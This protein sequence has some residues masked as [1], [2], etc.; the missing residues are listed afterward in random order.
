MS[1]KILAIKIVNHTFKS[2]KDKGNNNYN[3]HLEYVAENSV[4]KLHNNY[5]KSHSEIVFI[6]GLL[7]D[8]IEDSKNWTF[9]NLEPL[10]DKE[11]VDAIKVLT[12]QKNEDYIEDYIE[13]IKTNRLALIVKLT[14]LEHNLN[15]S[16]LDEISDYSIERIKKYHK[17][18]MTLKN[19]ALIN[20]KNFINI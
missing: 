9:E 13:R 19:N 10:F 7:H 8:L 3:E 12:K 16:R 18:Y 6:I 20:H 17:A 14:D 4:K 1:E 5:V 2:V 11:I 15:V